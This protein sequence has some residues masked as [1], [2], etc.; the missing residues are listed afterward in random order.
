[1][2]WLMN[3][4]HLETFHHFCRF[5]NMSRAAEHLHITQPAVSQQLRAFQAECGVQL[6]YREAKQYKLTSTGEDLFLLSKRIFLRIEQME[7]M[8]ARQREAD[9]GMLRVGIAKAYAQIIM[10]D[11]MEKFQRKYPKTHVLLSEANS[12]DL[13]AR[14]RRGKEDLVLIA[15]SDYDSSLQAVNFAR[16]ELVLV[17]RPDHPLTQ[18]GTI[19]IKRLNEESM[20]TRESGSGSR[21]AVIQT[22]ERYGVT[23]SVIIESESLGFIL[24]YLERRMGVAFIL[25]HEIV[26]ELAQGTLKQIH[27][28]EGTIV[29][30]ADIVRRRNQPVSLPLAY[31]F[32]VLKKHGEENLPQ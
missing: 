19:S 5:M 13:L 11:I 12:A 2:R 24:G 18:L 1:M 15:R 17:A 25:S 22:L 9:A 6:F 26:K 32:E 23:P 30:K 28:E 4:N 10:P 8:L 14:L 27:L 7:E 29:F 31:F 21:V 20:I 3:L 16:A